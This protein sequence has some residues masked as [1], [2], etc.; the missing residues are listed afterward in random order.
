MKTFKKIHFRKGW[1]KS[2]LAAILCIGIVVGAGFGIA[3]LV[4]PDKVDDLVTYR[5]LSATK[6]RIGGL[7]SN[8]NYMNTDKSIYTKDAFDCQGLNCTLDFDNVISYQVYFYDQNNEFVHTTGRLTGA[9]VQD[10]VPFF[11][12][13]ARIVIIPNDDN[14]VS[15]T[16]VAKYAKQL[17]V[18]MYRE[19]GFKNYTENLLT[20]KTYSSSLSDTD[21]S[22]IE[23]TETW[24]VS[25]FI[26]VADYK[27]V[28]IFKLDKTA[29]SGSNLYFY[30]A[31]K[32]FITY[33]NILSNSTS[34]TSST[35]TIYYSFDLTKVNVESF[36][37][38]RLNGNSGVELYCR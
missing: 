32:K 29:F 25:E 7:D 20:K 34:F 17:K 3:S 2:L 38:I 15:L 5:S 1:W 12:K 8:G 16:E 18:E 11:A 35:G 4:R 36:Q 9:F 23:S 19:Q 13:Y 37:Y 10:S 14:K 30:G 22:V 24:W 6:Y 33:K 31:D 26:N 28:L 27:E 21:G